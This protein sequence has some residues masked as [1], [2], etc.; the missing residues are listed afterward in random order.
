MLPIH[1]VSWRIKCILR[2][3]VDIIHSWSFK[4]LNLLYN[5]KSVCIKQYTNSKEIPLTKSY[6]VGG[7]SLI[8]QADCK[9]SV[10][11]VTQTIDNL[12][13]DCWILVIIF[14]LRCHHSFSGKNFASSR[15]D[16]TLRLPLHT[17]VTFRLFC[18]ANSGILYILH[19]RRIYVQIGRASCRERV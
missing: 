1:S 9:C 8:W 10:C 4:R 19:L 6:L 16:Q 3:Y 7:I 18:I 5:R 17:V 14:A 15:S 13:I 12:N 2:L 11:T